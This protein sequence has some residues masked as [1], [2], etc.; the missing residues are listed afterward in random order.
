[1]DVMNK[2]NQEGGLGIPRLGVFLFSIEHPF[3]R[4]GVM[5]Y[6]TQ[7]GL[8]QTEGRE[9]GSRGQGQRKP[10]LPSVVLLGDT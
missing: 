6:I 5:K 1:M 7:G 9:G 8:K 3:P 4:A 2:I 10:C